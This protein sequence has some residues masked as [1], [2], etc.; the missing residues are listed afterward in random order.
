VEEVE[1]NEINSGISRSIVS[2]PK[3]DLPNYS[4]MSLQDQAHQRSWFTVQFN[5][6]KKEYPDLNVIDVS[7]TESLYEIHA[8]YDIYLRHT[9]IARDVGKNRMWLGFMWVTI[10]VIFGAFKLDIS[11]YCESQIA[12]LKEYD[13]LLFELGE[14]NYKGTETVNGVSTSWPIEINIFIM[15]ITNA[16]I[17]LGIRYASKYLNMTPENASNLINSLTGLLNG[18]TPTLGQS[19]PSNQPNQVQAPSGGG[20]N[21][22]SIMNMVGPLL[23]GNN[24]MLQGLIGNLM[25]GGGQSIQQPIAA[26]QPVSVQQPVRFD[27]PHEE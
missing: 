1:S 17:F 27:P 2:L 5:K 12:S 9:Y 20:L 18:S 21:L 11:G 7:P 24:N 6:I 25:G 10:Q 19:L 8:R 26:S 4:A 13:K 3:L 15:S 16:L 23:G 22:G 14:L